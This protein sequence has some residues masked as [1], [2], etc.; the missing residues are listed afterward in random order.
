[1]EILVDLVIKTADAVIEQRI[2]DSMITLCNNFFAYGGVFTKVAPLTETTM[3][4]IVDWLKTHLNCD[5]RT[6]FLSPNCVHYWSLNI[7]SIKQNL[8]RFLCW[9]NNFTDKSMEV[10]IFGKSLIVQN[11][12]Y[13]HEAD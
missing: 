6:M 4:F 3:R 5:L 1:V 7:M 8:L 11:G 13:A 9:A 2:L 12:S 10:D